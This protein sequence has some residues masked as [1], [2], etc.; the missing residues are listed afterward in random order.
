MSDEVFVAADDGGSPAA[1]PT[2]P[3]A[4]AADS[5]RRGPSFDNVHKSKT[6]NAGTYSYA[7][8]D[9]GDLVAWPARSWRNTTW[10]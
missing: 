7:Y 4:M 10:R 6:A 3:P 9:L 2:I 8:G 1:A 5:W